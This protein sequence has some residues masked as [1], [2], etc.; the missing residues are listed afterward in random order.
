MRGRV[1][2]IGNQGRVLERILARCCQSGERISW[3]AGS[4]SDRS[5]RPIARN[6]SPSSGELSLRS[7]TLPARLES[8]SGLIPPISGRYPVRPPS[9]G[10]HHD[11]GYGRPHA[12]CQSAQ[13]A[14]STRCYCRF[15]RIGRIAPHLFGRGW[16][17]S[18]WPC[19]ASDCA[20]WHSFPLAVSGSMN[21]C[22]RSTSLSARRDSFS[23]RSTGTRARRWD[24]SCLP[25]RRFCSLASRNGRCGS[26]RSWAPRSA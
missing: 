6:Q 15:R 10:P 9:T 5:K 20:S 25:S 18:L 19:W 2:G 23:H 26:C 24:S 14:R 7:L 4:V 13:S 11:T 8:A 1:N 17:S 3:R 21:R 12:A 22:S 16:A